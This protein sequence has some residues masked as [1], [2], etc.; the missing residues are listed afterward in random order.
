[1]ILDII[2]PISIVAM[3]M[4]LFWQYVYFKSQNWV[5]VQSDSYSIESTKKSSFDFLVPVVIIL[6]IVNILY[7]FRRSHNPARLSTIIMF[8]V[9]AAVCLFILLYWRRKKSL[10]PDKVLCLIFI[11][12][13][14][15]R[16]CFVFNNEVYPMQH[17]VFSKHGHMEYI[18]HIANTW[19]LPTTNRWQFYQPPLFHILSAVIFSLARATFNGNEFAAMSA[20]QYF[21]VAISLIMILMF[22][23]LLKQVKIPDKWR[24]FGVSI[25][26]L[27]P[28]NILLSRVLNNDLLFYFF[29]LLSLITLIRWYESRKTLDMIWL[30]LSVSLGTLAKVSM[31]AFGLILAFV[32]LTVLL[33]DTKKFL[34][35][36]KQYMIFLGIFL[37]LGCSYIIR[38]YMLFKQSP[39]SVPDLGVNSGQ[40]IAAGPA[41]RLLTFPLKEFF[42]DPFCNVWEDY[43]IWQYM[44]K[45]S[46]FGEYR[47]ELTNIIKIISYS[48]LILSFVCIAIFL[49]SLIMSFKKVSSQKEEM[50][51]MIFLLIFVYNILS[52]IMFCFQYP[53]GCSMDF[54]YIVPIIF[55]GCYF[56]AKG[57][58]ITLDL[59]N[60]YRAKKYVKALLIT[61]IVLFLSLSV[62]FYLLAVNK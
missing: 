19:T 8:G 26:I 23:Y 24:V 51:N 25:F 41:Q 60:N 40:Y 38:N 28:Q 61:P 62:S 3:G 47:F 16:I 20:V 34:Y 56:L 30:A 31:M 17:D 44:I 54:R 7:F 58:P 45:C 50:F 46:L 11:I 52:Y 15:I 53:Q 18:K 14:M 48:L 55:S 27:Y 1:M 12:G 32:F 4:L 29:S 10:T 6:V 21:M 59:I 36:V 35:Y 2:T 43:N 33:R 5:K 22:N 49:F 39:L 37:T 13:V 57:I 9:T 42:S